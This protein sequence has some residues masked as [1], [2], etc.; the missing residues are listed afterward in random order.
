MRTQQ[1]IRKSVLAHPKN[2]LAHMED[3][4]LRGECELAQQLKDVCDGSGKEIDPFKSAAI[5]HALGLIYRHRSPD[6]FSLIK[7]AGLL[8]GAIMRK[9]LNVSAIEQDLTDLCK[10]ILL[11]AEAAKQ[12]SDFI[13]KAEEVKSSFAQ[14]RNEVDQFL[15]KSKS[16]DYEISTESAQNEITTK[17]EEDKISNIQTI[18]TKTTDTYMKSIANLFQYCENFLDSSRANTLSSEWDHS[19][20]MRPLHIPI[21]NI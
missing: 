12:T 14:L 10:H 13:E 16:T 20:V 2:D 8:N 1:L 18:R 5:F 17:P 4:L 19:P 15:S 3:E 7:S 11:Q 21:L 6:K 9:L